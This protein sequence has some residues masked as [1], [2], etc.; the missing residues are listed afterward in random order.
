MQMEPTMSPEENLNSTENQGEEKTPSVEENISPPEKEEEVKPEEVEVKPTQTSQKEE[1]KVETKVEAAFTMNLDEL[2]LEEYPAVMDKILKS[3]QWMKLGTQVREIQASFEKKF[4]K[5]VQEKKETFIAEGGNEIDFYF[6]PEYKKNFSF[7][8]RE[9][10]NKKGQHFKE[11]EANQKANLSRKKEIIEEIKQ[12]IDQSEHNS[13]SYKQFKNLQEAFHATGQVPRA[14]S[15]NIWQTYKFHVERF[16]DFLHLNRDL[17]EADFKHNYTEKLKFIERAEELAKQTDVIASMRELNNLHRLWKNDLGPVAHE[18]RED[19][20]NRFQAATKAIHHLKNEYNKNIDSIQEDNLAI[21]NGVLNEIKELLENKPEN[22]NAWQNA[23]KKVN[24]LKEKF[25]A[26]GRVPKNENKRLW[27]SF[28]ELSRQFNQEKNHFYKQQKT[29]EKAFVDAKR[30]LID[31]VKAIL[32]DPNYRDH[33]NRMKAIQND[34]KKTGRISRRLSN[35]LWEEFKALTNL[36]FDR[37]KNKVEAL[38]AEDQA[39]LASQTNFVEQVLKTE[40]PTTPK[41]L[42]TFI[43][44]Q[45]EQWQGLNPEA[46]SPA[47]R[48]LMQH[49]V[50]LWDASSLSAKEKGSQKFATQL[51]L[52]KNDAEALNKEHTSQKKKIDEIATELIQLQNNLQFFSNSSSDNPVVV[53]VNNKIELLSNQKEALSEK[54]NAIKSFIRSL[55][56]Q[57]EADAVEDV[58]ESGDE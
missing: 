6:A 27:N 2:A 34:W 24:T 22:H 32:D 35:K 19:L 31:E 12:L 58:E 56:K 52:I 49:L 5:E 53:E 23:I 15:N 40:A 47:Q 25:H 14:E 43:N 20:W 50:G 18:H 42:E 30:A 9:Y 17:R 8:L 37:I 36:Y 57:E 33:I 21:K 45:V 41:K 1:E 38:S 16:Y 48:K 51:S 7:A 11:I 39:K 10:K 54:A 4:Q 26:V 28:R 13:T 29:E 55:K 44:E 46:S 3:D